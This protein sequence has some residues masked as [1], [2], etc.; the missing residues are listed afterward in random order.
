MSRSDDGCTPAV[1]EDLPAVAIGVD[2]GCIHV[3]EN[4]R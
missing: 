1:A 4:G 3:P 2:G